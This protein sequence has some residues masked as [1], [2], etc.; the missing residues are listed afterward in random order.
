MQHARA[1]AQIHQLSGKMRGCTNTAR[2]KANKV[3]LAPHQ[4]YK[5]SKIARFKRSAGNQ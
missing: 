1:K 2:R 5:I 4:I 3:W